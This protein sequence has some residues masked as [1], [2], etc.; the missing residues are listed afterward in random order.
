MLCSCFETLESYHIGKTC[1]LGSNNKWSNIY[2]L[3]VFIKFCYRKTDTPATINVAGVC[4]CTIRDS[5][6]GHLD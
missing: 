6:P 5:N 1:R 2:L 3:I 4:W